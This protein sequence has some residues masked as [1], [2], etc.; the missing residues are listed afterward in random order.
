MRRREFI[1]LISGAAFAQPLGARGQQRGKIYR[2][3]FLANDPTISR[4]LLL[5]AD[6]VIE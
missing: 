2:I 5:I 4:S 3:G 1:K 6:E